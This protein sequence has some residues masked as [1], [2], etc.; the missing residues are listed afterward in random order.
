M[1]CVHS[2]N[3]HQRFSRLGSLG[4]AL[5]SRRFLV[6]SWPWRAAGFS[7]VSVARTVLIIPL[8][9]VGLPFVPLIAV[10]FARMERRRGRVLQLRRVSS[11]HDPF[12]GGRLSSWVSLR[13]R[14]PATWRDTAALLV[15]VTSGIAQGFAVLVP[16]IYLFFTLFLPGQVVFYQ[17]QLAETGVAQPP[18]VPLPFNHAVWITDGT[19]IV[20]VFLFVATSFAVGA[21]AVGFLVLVETSVTRMLL[22]ARPEELEAQVRA[23]TDSRAHLAAA[24]DRQRD[25]IGRNLHDGVQQRCVTAALLV[26]AAE[27]EAAD[28]R[29]SGV[30]TSGLDKALDAAHTAI[31]SALDDLRA[32]M[33]GIHPAVLIDRGLTEAVRDLVRFSPL[34]VHIRSSLEERLTPQIE[35]CAFYVVSESI[36]NINRHARATNVNI[37]ISSRPETLYVSVVDDGIGGA[38]PLCGTGLRG[39]AARAHSVGGCMRVDSPAAGPT[40]VELELPLATDE[41]ET[42]SP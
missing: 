38:D 39:L 33:R 6:S 12:T 26:G 1:R 8:L 2:G 4:K 21:Y 42:R 17:H 14:E 22:S 13:Y 27:L 40:V 9:I 19:G 24:L 29:A 7:V 37:T 5:A 11:G 36:S 28:L 18:G 35:A 32:V 20:L 31:E 15:S 25:E 3:S 10:G 30:P 16:P 34:T 23:L 41:S